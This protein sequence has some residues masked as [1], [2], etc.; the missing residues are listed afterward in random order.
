MSD[1]NEQA[2]QRRAFGARL[3]GIRNAAGL[4]QER[5]AHASELDR[6]YIGAVENGRRNLSLHAMWQ[7]AHALETTPA[8]FFVEQPTTKHP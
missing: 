3:R 6:T 1:P 7:L 4:S 8:E 2:A 5:L